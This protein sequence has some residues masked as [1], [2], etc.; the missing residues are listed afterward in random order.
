M[1]E[2]PFF[3]GWED[4]PAAASVSHSRSRA[5]ILLAI[6]LVLA[7]LVAALQKGFRAKGTWD[8][9]QQTFTGILLAEPYPTLVSGDGI[10]Y[11]VM[12][13]K[14]GV[15]V[16][17][18]Q[19]FD[20]NTVEIVGSLIEDPDQPV[21]MIAVENTGAITSTG[22]ANSNPL[23]LAT[24]SRQVTLRGEIIDSKCAFGAMNPGVLKTHRACAI[25]C[26]SGD[27]PPVLVVRHDGGASA[28]HYLLLNDDGKP[29]KEA[30]IKFAALPVEITGTVTE[31]GSWKIL[32]TTPTAIALLP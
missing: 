30:A 26:L 16:S 29:I 23:Q 24:A 19:P 3:I 4:R 1:S 18:A 8:F 12:Q 32:K 5:L 7:G 31:V 15:A 20:L 13:N 14:Q 21:A 28:T 27:I 10:Y 22:T 17:D 11:L 2:K 6:F 25:V 9:A